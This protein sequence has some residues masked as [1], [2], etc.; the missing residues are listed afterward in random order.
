M[1]NLIKFFISRILKKSRLAA[2]RDSFVHPAAKIESGSSFISSSIDRYSFCGYDCDVYLARIGKFTSI[3]SGVV[4]GGARHPMEWVGMSPAFY[5]GRDSIKS[6]FAEHK[7]R[8]HEG[9][10]I[11]HDVW[12][13]RSAIVLA[14]V[15][16]G[17]GSVIGA[18]SVVTKDVPPYAIVAGNPARLIR[19]RFDENIIRKL[20]E[21]KWW[22]FSEAR[23]KTF[24][25]VFNDVER[26]LSAV[27]AESFD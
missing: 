13:G 5:A 9:V 22:N 2:I 21:I 23:L 14:G 1:L 26:F 10:I 3:A 24:G 7:L 20:E 19:Y 18:G 12:I 6:K 4:I 15:T 17:D 25:G 27:Q 8:P 11:G 16:V